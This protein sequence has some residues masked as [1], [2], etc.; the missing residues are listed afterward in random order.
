VKGLRVV[1]VLGV[2]LVVSLIA[3]AYAAGQDA[4][5]MNASDAREFTIRA[6]TF[7]GFDGVEVTGEPRAEVF[8]AAEQPSSDGQDREN[9]V[10]AGPPIPVWVVPATVSGQQIEL[11][12]AAESDRAVNLDDALPGGGFVLDEEQFKRLERFRLDPAGDQ[13]RADRGGPAVAA[14][15]LIVVV[16]L[17]LVV[18]LVRGRRGRDTS[19]EGSGRDV[20]PATE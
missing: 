2:V 8:D 15:L 19:A 5:P 4:P 3:G 12:V 20:Q 7:S 9:R 1:I 6:L 13:L 10:E 18:A 11:Y 17:L 16:T 14:G